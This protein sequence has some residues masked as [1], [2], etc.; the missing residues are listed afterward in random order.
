MNTILSPV[1]EKMVNNLIIENLLKNGNVTIDEAQFANELVSQI[2]DKSLT[3][4]LNNLNESINITLAQ[5]QQIIEE[6]AYLNQYN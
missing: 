5:A 2:V 4:D 3:N 6:A 1:K